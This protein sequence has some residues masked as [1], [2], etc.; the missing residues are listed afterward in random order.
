MIAVIESDAVEVEGSEEWP[1]IER[2]ETNTKRQI[3]HFV[4]VQLPGGISTGLDRLRSG[5]LKG[6]LYTPFT[7]WLVTTVC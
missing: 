4:P 2:K 3:Y 7:D 1:A 5:W 6:L